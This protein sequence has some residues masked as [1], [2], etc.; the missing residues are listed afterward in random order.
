MTSKEFRKNGKE[1]IDWIADYYDYVESHP[2]QS[3]VKPGD[4]RAS[5]PASAPQTGESFEHWMQDVDN[6][7]MPGITH[8]QSPNFFAFFPC[9]A[10]GPGILGDLLSSGLNVQGMMWATSPACTE[11]ETLVLDWL[12]EMLDLPTKFTSAQTGGGVIQDSASSATLCAMLAARERVL[13][14][15]VTPESKAGQA[16]LLVAYASEEAHSSVEKGLRI[17]GLSSRKLRKIPADGDFAMDAALLGEAV[18]K[19]LE[20]GLIPFFV[21]ATVGTT[22]SNGMDPLVEIGQVCTRHSI[23]MHV[24]AAMSG[25]AA[26][27]PEFRAMHDGLEQADS[28]CFNP[29]KW[30]FTN[31][32]C[33]CFYV[34]DRSGLTDAMSILPEYLSNKATESEQVIDYRDWQIPLGRRFRALKLWYVI[35]HYGIQGLQHHIREH[36]RLAQTFAGWVERDANF[37]LLAPSP[38]N[39][40]CFAHRDGDSKTKQILEQANDSGKLYASHTVLKGRYAIRMSIG[41]THTELRHVEKAW[42]LFKEMAK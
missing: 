29:H 8:W 11:V 36:V 13:K 6:Y 39:L 35:R 1:L 42:D 24:D 19:D 32:D 28:Y 38:L 40:V 4:I 18:Q 12:V 34:A 37:E 21:S 10:S 31:F 26:I 25:T 27:C 30:M 20:N 9:N 7:I 16:E 41:Q 15:S 14:R 17:I 3:Q 23:W 33:D 2:V 22:S 5:L